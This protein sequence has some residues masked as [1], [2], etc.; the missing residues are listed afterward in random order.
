M[1]LP[2]S[3]ENLITLSYT[4]DVTAEDVH[5]H[6]KMFKVILTLKH[7]IS[8]TFWL[9]MPVSV[10]EILDLLIVLNLLSWLAYLSN[11]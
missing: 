6:K 3:T 1:T 5:E 2:I 10:H 11:K 4:L 7:L 8:M 9:G